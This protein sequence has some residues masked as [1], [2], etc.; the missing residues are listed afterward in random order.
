MLD[1][2]FSLSVGRHGYDEYCSLMIMNLVAVMDVY[3][4]NG[5]PQQWWTISA[6]VNSSFQCRVQ[7][8]A[9]EL[10]CRSCG[11]SRQLILYAWRGSQLFDAE[12]VEQKGTSQW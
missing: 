4:P 3:I 2:S 11:S 9:H 5:E 8:S 1:D 10:S 7:E 6:M 12:K